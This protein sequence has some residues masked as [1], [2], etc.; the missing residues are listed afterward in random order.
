MNTLTTFPF[1]KLEQENEN[2][3][4]QLSSALDRHLDLERRAEEAEKAESDSNARLDAKQ[5]EADRWRAEA[6]RLQG[7]G[8]HQQPVYPAEEMEEL[9]RA[10][11]E[12]E[13]D[14]RDLQVQINEEHQLLF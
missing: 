13:R 5:R 11:M 4:Q 1:R 6:A 8:G 3:K 9:R 7:V 10:K 14:N 12:L 2:L